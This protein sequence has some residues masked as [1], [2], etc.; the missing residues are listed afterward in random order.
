MK[1]QIAD[2]K[3]GNLKAKRQVPISKYAYYKGLGY[4][5]ED[6]DPHHV[7]LTQNENI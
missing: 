6:V 1:I 7:K 3:R 2:C 5:W 4:K